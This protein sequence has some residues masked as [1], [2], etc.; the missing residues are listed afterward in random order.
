MMI[1]VCLKNIFVATVNYLLPGQKK[2]CCMMSAVCLKKYVCCDSKLFVARTK[3]LLS[4]QNMFFFVIIMR[5]AASCKKSPSRSPSSVKTQLIIVRCMFVKMYVHWQLIRAYITTAKATGVVWLHG[6][7]S[8]VTVE[9][10]SI[11]MPLVPL[12]RPV[13]VC[14]QKIPPE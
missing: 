1:A 9:D 3:K 2:N 7:S 8:N 5:R 6:G 14:T 4:Q 11:R 10:G 13:P 12:S